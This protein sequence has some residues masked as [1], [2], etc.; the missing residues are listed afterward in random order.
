MLK[1]LSTTNIIFPIIAF[2]AGSGFTFY[3]EKFKFERIEEPKLSMDF[4]KTS[5]DL[6]KFLN[7]LRPKLDLKCIPRTISDRK[8]EILCD[9]KN[10]GSNRALIDEPSASLHIRGTDNLIDKNEFLQKNQSKNALPSGIEGG[11]WYTIEFTESVDWSQIEVATEFTAKTDVTIVKLAKK[12]LLKNNVSAEDIDSLS[13]Q[14]YVSSSFP[15]NPEEPN[16]EAP[17][18]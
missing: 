6:S 7:D 18:S 15:D 12:M 16:E 2:I 3:I 11:S 14:G 8:I 17:P 13:Q 4:T 1:K 9:I 5:I 10:I